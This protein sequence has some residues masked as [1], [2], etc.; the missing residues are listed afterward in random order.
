MND[1]TVI[2][3]QQKMVLSMKDTVLTVPDG[4]PLYKSPIRAINA[5]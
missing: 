1:F 4:V 3:I 2:R 5:T